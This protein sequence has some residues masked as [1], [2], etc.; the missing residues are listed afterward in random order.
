MVKNHLQCRRSGF[1]PW[2]K[3]IPWRRELQST[4][5]FL[6]GKSY[7]QRTLRGQ[8]PWNHKESGMTKQLTLSHKQQHPFLKK[9][10]KQN[11]KFSKIIVVNQHVPCVLTKFDNSICIDESVIKDKCSEYLQVIETNSSVYNIL[12]HSIISPTFKC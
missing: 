11:S 8:C 7:G 4:P 1:S 12:S 10:L 9:S 2:V 6:P 5:V 3:K